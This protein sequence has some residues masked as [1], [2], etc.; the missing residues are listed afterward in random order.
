MYPTELT[1]K[2]IRYKVVDDEP[3]DDDLVITEHYGVWE[4]KE[5]PH[6]LPYWCNRYTCKKL[7]PISNG[8]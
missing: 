3:K 2:G 8:N 5:T 1:H 6:M 7:I 4:F